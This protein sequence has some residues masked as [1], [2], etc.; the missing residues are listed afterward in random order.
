[1]PVCVL[2]DKHGQENCQL[3]TYL[4]PL[5][6]SNYKS[7]TVQTGLKQNSNNIRA[8][9]QHTSGATYSRFHFYSSSSYCN[10]LYVWEIECE[11]I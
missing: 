11:H 3:A 6:E 7:D 10:M 5:S 2:A 8:A 4:R 1:M 9:I